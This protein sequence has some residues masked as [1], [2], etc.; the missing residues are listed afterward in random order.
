[1]ALADGISFVAASS[2][3][4]TFVFG[5]ARVSFLTLSQAQALGEIT[6]GQT[7]SYLA[8]DSLTNPTQREWG[9]GTYSLSGNSIARTTVLGTVN[10]TVTGT[11]S[12]LGF[13]TAP[14][15]SL[16]ALAEDIVTL[17]G[18]TMLSGIAAAS[19][20]AGTDTVIGVQGGNTDAQYAFTQVWTIAGTTV[21]GLPTPATGMIG[22]VTDGSSGLTSGQTVTGSHSTPYLVWY[23]GT[24]WTV[25]GT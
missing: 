7:V 1:M 6:D 20:P 14:I 21:S 15:V 24:N 13:A 2:G 12:A 5:T 17:G 19:A 11:G 9:H 22:R 4:G 8:Q 18:G 25:I 3:T 10:G 16:T 23:N